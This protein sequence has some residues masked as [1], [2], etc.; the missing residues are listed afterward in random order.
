M[1]GAVLCHPVNRALGALP[2]ALLRRHLLRAPLAGPP[3]PRSQGV[4][5][6][7]KDVPLRQPEPPSGATGVGLH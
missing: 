1:R 2:W 3:R 4:P 5:G 7:R 6:V